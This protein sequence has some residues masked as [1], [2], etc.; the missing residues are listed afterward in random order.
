MNQDITYR[1]LIFDDDEPIRKV[2][3]R[4]FDHR[5]YDVFVFPQAR[6][7]PILDLHECP[8]PRY[9]VCAD[10]IVSDLNMPFVRGID[11]LE[12]QISKGCKV[13]NLALMTGE[14]QLPDR[15][16]ADKLGIRVF[17]KPFRLADMEKWVAE[18]EATIPNNRKLSD[19]HL[20]RK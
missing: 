4:Y 16:R 11:F 18:A 17:L 19:L 2:L 14:L 20:G 3:W 8:C 9:E 12:H 6:S 15:E 1:I 7:C 5:G 13:K 10:L